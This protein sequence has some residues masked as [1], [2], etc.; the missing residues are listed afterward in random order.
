MYSQVIPSPYI[1]IV[2]DNYGVIRNSEVSNDTLSRYFNGC[3]NDVF[4]AL[5]LYQTW[6]CPSCIALNKLSAGYG[7]KP[8]KCPNCR[9]P[10][11]EVATFQ[12]RASYSGD[13]FMYASLYLLKEKYGLNLK[14]TSLATRL[15]DL[16]L[17][18]DLV[19]EAKGSPVSVINP[20][21]SKSILGRAGMSR[22]DTKKKAFANAEEWRERV[23]NGEFFIITNS[24]PNSLQAYH[25]DTVSGI[26]DISKR[27]QLEKFVSELQAT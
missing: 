23:P 15:Y 21:G 7:K 26:Y 10:V 3:F 4:R 27:I 20:D 8:A 19:I 5:G 25:S 18:H 22:T 9:K 11:Y 1:T 12:A 13:A 2:R 6:V 17:T 14:P 24:M 16:E